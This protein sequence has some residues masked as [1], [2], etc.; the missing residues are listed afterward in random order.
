MSISV[1]EAV[2]PGITEEQH[3][4]KTEQLPASMPLQI[5][6]AA[7]EAAL[8][9]YPDDQ[10]FVDTLTVDGNSLSPLPDTAPQ[11]TDIPP[12]DHL[13]EARMEPP[14]VP[15]PA[16][17]P[18]VEP[19]LP[20]V[21]ASDP[22][23]SRSTQSNSMSGG[24]H[25]QTDA[26]DS[27]ES[28]MNKNYV[29]R[30]AIKQKLEEAVALGQMPSFCSNCGALQTPTWRK[31]WKQERRGVPEYHEYSEKPGHVTA[32]NVLERD[33]NGTPTSYEIIKKSLGPTDDKSTWAETILCNR[34]CCNCVTL[35]YAL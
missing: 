3:R 23:L 27:M 31:I 11:E 24:P 35:K 5:D 30:Q 12:T 29:K 18:S 22:V 19:E 8:N 33:D 28:R 32:I 20:A 17:E 13:Y 1:P 15:T 16:S 7:I 26:V 4:Q 25:P 10:Q 14:A 21:P 34:K 6:Y 2:E 9:E